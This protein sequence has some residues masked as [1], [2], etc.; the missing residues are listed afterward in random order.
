MNYMTRVESFKKA[1]FSNFE[2]PLKLIH[3][4]KYRHGRKKHQYI[5][6]EIMEEFNLPKDMMQDTVNF[7]EV[8]SQDCNV[9]RK[10]PYWS[11]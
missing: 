11:G 6:K 4:R 5:T 3:K 7:D 2:E 8:I 9:K 10:T 1:K